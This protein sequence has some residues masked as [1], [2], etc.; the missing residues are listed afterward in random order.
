[1]SLTG[2]EGDTKRA[3]TCVVLIR[4]GSV[5]LCGLCKSVFIADSMKDC[6]KFMKVLLQMQLSP[7]MASLFDVCMICKITCSD[8]FVEKVLFLN[9]GRN[10]SSYFCLM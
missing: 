9:K 7:S 3:M 1:M 2:K 8:S 6:Q 10:I 5:N 4:N